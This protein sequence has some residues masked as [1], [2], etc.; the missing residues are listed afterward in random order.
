MTLNSDHYK[1]DGPEPVEYTHMK[2]DVGIIMD[3]CRDLSYLVYPYGGLVLQ[4]QPSN[5]IHGSSR[6]FVSFTQTNDGYQHFH[7]ASGQ[8]LVINAK[9]SD[10]PLQAFLNAMKE[11]LIPTEAKFK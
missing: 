8:G 2:D 10:D 6:F 4:L 3:A 5:Y 9:T 1:Y 7:E 11:N